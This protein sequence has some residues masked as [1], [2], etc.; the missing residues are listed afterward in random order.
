MKKI[1]FFLIA[2]SIGISCSTGGNRKCLEI[3]KQLTSENRLLR[4]KISLLQ[5]E[6]GVFK[7]ENI[8]YKKDLENRTAEVEKLASEV[9]SIK[10]KFEGD[11]SLWKQK[12]NNLAEKNKILERESSEKIRELTELNR[13]LE[14]GF[15]EDIKKLSAN[16]RKKDEDFGVEREQLKKISAEN[17]FK[18]S[19]EIEDVKNEISVLEK[20]R[21]EMT[22]KIHE[23]SLKLES[24]IREV[25][26]KNMLIRELK[27]EIPPPAGIKGKEDIDKE[28][29]NPAKEIKDNQ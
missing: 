18:R 20:E 5:R 13:Q 15:S 24:A 1:L 4:N 22:I 16:L 11:V 25:E 26:E 17:E 23:L 6:N 14:Q 19:R 9:E 21:S 10:E 8:Q 27:K 2:V 29:K 7:Y 28:I 3:N 12:Y